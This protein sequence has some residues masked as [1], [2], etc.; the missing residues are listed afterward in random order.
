[1]NRSW[2]VAILVVMACSSG[3]GP[4]AAKADGKTGAGGPSGEKAAAGAVDPALRASGQALV[5]ALTPALTSCHAL[6]DPL[7]PAAAEASKL[8]FEQPALDTACGPLRDLYDA[9]V[10]TVG[11][12]ARQIDLLL[13]HAARLGDGVDYLGRALVDIGT[14]R[15]LAVTQLQE[16]L[17]KASEAV[18]KWSEVKV[19]PYRANYTGEPGVKQWALDLENDG[20]DG[21]N[22]RNNLERFAIKQGLNPTQVRRRMLDVYGRIALAHQ[23]VRVAALE[24]SDL[25]PELK[26]SRGAYLKALAAWTDAYTS[27]TK[28]YIAGEVKDAA[29]QAKLT[30]QADAALAAFK[31]A[32]DA[33]KAAE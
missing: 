31:T 20:R 6:I 7:D 27:V 16:A 11:G 18:A 22:L 21:T 28:A 2:W 3:T 23:P 25:T 10:D 26:A 5:D 14:E 12:K 29:T 4:S 15:K 33:Q 19:Y 32:W 17:G 9:Q 30:A 13:T 24:A 1:M 8:A